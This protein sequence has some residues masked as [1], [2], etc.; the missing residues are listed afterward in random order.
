VLVADIAARATVDADGVR[1]SNY[2]H[3]QT[4]STLEPRTGWAMGNAGIVR[5]LLRFARIGTGGEPG[6]A[7]TWPDH[8]AVGG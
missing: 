5:E 2:E 1:W 8:P 3:R 7:V 6:Y 4:P